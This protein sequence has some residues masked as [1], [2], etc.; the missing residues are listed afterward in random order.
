MN[1]SQANPFIGFAAAIFAFAFG[2]L[3]VGA[4]DA[5]AWPSAR[6][7]CDDRANLWEQNVVA[8]PGDGTAYPDDG[9][10]RD[11]IVVELSGF[12]YTK[13]KHGF[14]QTA[15][16]HWWFGE[17][18]RF[19]HQKP[20][21]EPVVYPGKGMD[22]AVQEGGIFIGRIRTLPAR[23]ME[24]GVYK[25]LF[26]ARVP[27]DPTPGAFCNTPDH[28]VHVPSEYQ[29]ANLNELPQRL[30]YGTGATR[31]EFAWATV[32][33]L[34]GDRPKAG[35]GAFRLICPSAGAG[36]VAGSRFELETVDPVPHFCPGWIK[37]YKDGET[38]P[39]Q[40][41]LDDGNGNPVFGSRNYR[42]NGFGNMPGAGKWKAFLQCMGEPPT[43]LGEYLLS[44]APKPPPPPPRVVPV[45]KFDLALRIQRKV[46]PKSYNAPYPTFGENEV[47]P[48]MEL[49]LAVARPPDYPYS[50][51]E[52]ER[53]EVLLDGVRLAESYPYAWD[54]Y[55]SL[56]S[57]LSSGPHR[58][59]LRA[60]HFEENAKIEFEGTM[61]IDAVGMPS[62]PRLSLS[63]PVETGREAFGAIAPVH[64]KMEV[65][66]VEV[67]DSDNVHYPIKASSSSAAGRIDLEFQVPIERVWR[68]HLGSGQASTETPV[69]LR[70]NYRQ[71]IGDAEWHRFQVRYPVR[72]GIVCRGK[73]DPRIEAS[74]ANFVL[75]PGGA[76]ALKVSGFPC[77]DRISVHS[78]GEGGER[79][80]WGIASTL[81]PGGNV[82]GYDFDGSGSIEVRGI[83]E[84]VSPR[85]PQRLA[86]IV[87]GESGREARA[88]I[89]VTPAAYIEVTP[90][91]PKSGQWIQVKAFGFK[92][93]AYAHVYLGE[94]RLT[95]EHGKPLEAGQPLEIRLPE[96]V[97]GRQTVRVQDSADHEA[98]DTIEISGEGASAVCGKPCI[99]LPRKAKQGDLFD[100]V[101]GGFLKNEQLV[102]R[103]DGLFEVA[104][105]YQRDLMVKQPVRIPRGLG[106][107]RYRV[108]AASLNDPDRT[109]SAEFD[110]EGGRL[111]PT[112]EIPCPKNQPLCGAPRFQPGE[113]VHTKGIGWMMKGRF[114][115]V[116]YPEQGPP[117]AFDEYREG[118]ISGIVNGRLQGSPCDEEKGEIDKFWA[119]PGDARGGAWVIE[120]S[121]GVASARAGFMVEAADVPAE[122]PVAKPVE[123]PVDKVDEPVDKPVAVVTPAPPARNACNPDLPKFWQPGCV[124]PDPGGESRTAGGTPPPRNICDPNRPRYAQPG[125]VEAGEPARTDGGQGMREKCNPSVPSYAQ[126]GCIP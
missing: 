101:I 57:T 25:V 52:P 105:P 62:P 111:P 58:V 13:D 6:L 4:P 75:R 97:A 39:W 3:S 69:A 48:G 113:S 59:T 116:L 23:Q 118:C 71:K 38:F 114:R 90:R 93:N 72:V 112:L 2:A 120:V 92:A 32:R 104:K 55:F 85:K 43:L 95:P 121:D 22:L 84:R 11:G 89:T 80:D 30:L 64:P 21:F 54:T 79:I 31:S 110:V 125:C 36:C 27:C 56:P 20:F 24:P 63:G 124:E 87:K 61:A 46:L 102:V 66:S 5:G 103:L 19:V 47:Y 26:Q 14:P 33:I 28:A 7:L 8:C 76:A 96:G 81:G 109:A 70:V 86:F 17:D 1:R 51:R 77:G 40:V 50:R 29:P 44:E 9:K 37:F 53:Y 83:E 65:E 88:A 16:D 35:P 60:G 12:P 78:E 100:A 82:I 18:G 91:T 126:A 10:L 41:L 107:G 94:A 98:A 68:N 34:P 119:L 122:K 106:D 73:V 108:T 117:R 49:Q 74:P 67:P 15:I 45:K 42:L 123:K 99:L 115:A